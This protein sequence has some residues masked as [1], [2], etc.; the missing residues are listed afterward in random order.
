MKIFTMM[1]Y[2]QLL[3]KLLFKQ[4]GWSFKHSGLAN[5]YE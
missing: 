4:H 3:L 2:F 5:G 1:G